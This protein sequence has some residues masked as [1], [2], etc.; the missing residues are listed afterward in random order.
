MTA[1]SSPNTIMLR[2][3]MSHRMN[4]ALAVVLTMAEPDRTLTAPPAGSR[5]PQR[6][7]SATVRTMC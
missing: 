3:V 6:V 1:P 2:V 5:V 4:E 7:M